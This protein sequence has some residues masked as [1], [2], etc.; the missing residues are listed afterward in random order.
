MLWKEIQ[1]LIACR[2]LFYW[3]VPHLPRVET[4]LIISSNSL[5]V[6]LKMET[7]EIML[8]IINTKFFVILVNSFIDWDNL[9]V[10]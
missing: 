10:F 5:I 1:M 3:A 6:D 4:C 7:V 2:D 9:S 8:L